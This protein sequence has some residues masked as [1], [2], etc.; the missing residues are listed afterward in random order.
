MIVCLECGHHNTEGLEFCESCGT[1]LEWK[2]ERQRDRTGELP[3]QRQ[4]TD[5]L[6][7]VPGAGDA[8]QLPTVCPRCGEPGKP[9]LNY[10]S[11]CGRPLVRRTGSAAPPPRRRARAAAAP[12]PWW[13]SPLVILGALALIA[14]IAFVLLRRDAAPAVTPQTS[15]VEQ[16]AAAPSSP[17]PSPP[18]PQPSAPA[19]A[20]A[21]LDVVDVTASTV[22]DPDGDIIYDPRVTLDGD[23]ATAWNDGVRGTPTGESLEYRFAA[24]VQITR[25]ELINGYDK[26]A[27]DGD[28]FT[29]N[30]RIRMARIQTDSGETL[31]QLQDTRE[32]Q[33]VTG[34]FGTT[35]RVTLVVESIYPGEDFEDVALSEITFFGTADVGDACPA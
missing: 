14:G 12:R 15:V 13:R 25:I 8:D 21:R 2:G 16:P 9:G 4:D 26:V 22:L 18:P 19:V 6:S 34:D 5:E 1:F 11:R 3:E 32:P 29:Q 35:C 33:S 10:C 20:E 7:V 17:A 27:D 31:Q 30:A 23:P 28:R 24:P